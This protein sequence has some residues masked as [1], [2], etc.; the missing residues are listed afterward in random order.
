LNCAYLIKIERLKR[1][2]VFAPGTENAPGLR[3]VLLVFGAGLLLS[4]LIETAQLWLPTRCTDVNDV[5]FNPL[6]PPNQRG[7]ML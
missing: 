5:I 7:L 3:R 4:A 6:H 1:G 2:L